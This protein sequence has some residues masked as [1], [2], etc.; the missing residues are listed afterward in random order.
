MLLRSSSKIRTLPWFHCFLV[1]GPIE[2]RNEIS[3]E[4]EDFSES[5]DNIDDTYDNEAESDGELEDEDEDDPE[6]E[7]DNDEESD[8]EIA[9]LQGDAMQL[10]GTWSKL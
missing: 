10:N 1:K 9:E 4:E 3:S 6:S 2:E 8:G 5:D 7:D